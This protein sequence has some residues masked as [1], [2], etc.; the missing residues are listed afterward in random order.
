MDAKNLNEIYL[1][2]S[3]LAKT[4]LSG[5][6]EQILQYLDMIDPYLPIIAKPGNVFT[7]KDVYTNEKITEYTCSQAHCSISYLQLHQWSVPDFRE[8]TMNPIENWMLTDKIHKCANCFTQLNTVIHPNSI[9]ITRIIDHLN[10]TYCDVFT[11]MQ[12]IKAMMLDFK[13]IHPRNNW[14]EDYFY[15]ACQLVEILYKYMENEQEKN[16]SWENNI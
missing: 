10:S 3:H 6:V 4:M 14:G 2:D 8:I 16:N 1:S 13:W 5:F 7:R 12:T 9:S 15:E 11:E